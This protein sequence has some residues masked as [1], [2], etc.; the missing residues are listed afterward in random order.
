M[1]IPLLKL[2][3]AG[4]LRNYTVFPFNPDIFVMRNQKQ[5]KCIKFVMPHKYYLICYI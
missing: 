3:A 2:T 1:W 5:C 4:Q